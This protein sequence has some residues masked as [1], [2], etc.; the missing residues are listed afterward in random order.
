MKTK[1]IQKELKNLKSPIL[2]DKIES[3][4]KNLPAKKSTGQYNIPSEL[5]QTLNKEIS[6]TDKGLKCLLNKELP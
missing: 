2:T 6:I 3:L 5:Y 4:I 1:L